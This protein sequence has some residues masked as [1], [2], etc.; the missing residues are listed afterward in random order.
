MAT[1]LAVAIWAG[2]VRPASQAQAAQS[3]NRARVQQEAEIRSADIDFW[4]RRAGEDAQSAEDRAM[5]AGLLA[6]RAREGGGVEDYRAAERLAADAL[7]LRSAGNGKA[8]LVL[9]SSLLAQHRFGEA[10]DEAKQL[11]TDA[12]EEPGYRALLAELFV[13]MGRYDEARAQ[14]DSLAAHR[15][16]LSV[17]PRYARYLEFRG[18][19]ERARRLLSDARKEAASRSGLPR[20]QVAWFALR[21]A[22]A[23]LR[24][25]RLDVAERALEEGLA[26]VPDDGRLW[27]LQARL[28]AVRGEWRQSLRAVERVGDAMDLATRSLGGDVYAALGDSAEARRWWKA[29]EQ[30]AL[31]NPEPYNRQWT[32]FRL[33]QGIA[34]E[35]TRALLEREITGRTDVFGWA[36]L[37]WAR[38]QTGDV[39][40]ARAAMQ[41]A[42]GMG[43]KD[44]WLFYVAGLVAAAS[45]DESEARNWF[46]RALEVNAHFHHRYADDARRR[47]AQKEAL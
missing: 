13:E 21:V 28:H 22:D 19:G 20:E 6:Q 32:M 23:Y 1:A 10:L 3:A 41:Q 39:Q 5:A 42:T 35:E 45:G 24:A 27:A 47:L 16:S 17:A 11:V 14:F 25:G 46:T 40:G 43:M 7:R 12:P 30:Q 44:G 29:T 9:A 36:Q 33:E 26:E 2:V 31:D 18:E 38:L 34:L 15:T 4:L 8:R 37:G